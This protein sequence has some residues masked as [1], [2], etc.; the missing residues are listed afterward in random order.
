MITFFSNFISGHQIPF[1]NA[2]YRL[3]DGGFRFVATEAMDQERLD[4][5]F[6]DETERFPYVVKVYDSKADYQEALRLGNESDV[7]II[8]SAPD[9]F[10]KE[11]LRENKLTFR[12]CERYFK[13]GRWR[14]LDPRVLLSHFKRDFINR[15]KNLHMLCAS[16]YTAPDCRFIFSYPN[17]TFKWG[18]F[19]KVK[20]YNI[21]DLMAKKA[22]NSPSILWAGRL[23]GWKHPD[24]SIKVAKQL[25]KAGYYFHLNIVGSGVMEERLRQMIVD[26]GLQDCVHL[27]GSMR[28]DK[29]REHMEKADIFL[30]TSDRQEG[31]GAVL[32]ESMNSACAVVACREIGS[33]PYLIEDGVNGL[34]YNRS[35]KDSLYHNV[36]RLMDDLAL[37]KNLQRNACKTMKDMWN[38]NIASE[39][40]LFLID[41]I[42]KGRETGYTSGP[43]SRA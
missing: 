22:E 5:G 36:K 42:Q 33:V 14:I 8:G 29:V 31:W 32:N 16:A 25:K 11:R 7:V 39:R 2:M 26:K 9:I 35:D 19:P 6:Q 41:C 4:L 21:D 43:C 28:P 15:N 1:C 40:L 13:T 10:I 12:Y 23:I 17:K 27:L 34:V 20:V 38:A 30:F 18:Y 3:T 24:A 37:R